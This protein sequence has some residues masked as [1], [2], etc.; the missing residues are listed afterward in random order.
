VTRCFGAL[1][2]VREKVDQRMEFDPY[3]VLSV[4][5]TATADEI[6]RAYL[7]Q[8]R[9]HHPDTRPP[10]LQS[11]PF[12]DEPL[13]R[14]VA[15]YALLRDPERRAHYDRA[16]ARGDSVA[17]RR[18]SAPRAPTETTSTSNL[19]RSVRIPGLNVR[20]RVKWLSD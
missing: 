20:F 13:R 7:R 5:V 9:V 6:R 10:A 19:A 15:A 18:T 4:P 17:E 3:A 1:S 11:K 16:L 2:P 12:A 14:V 8:V